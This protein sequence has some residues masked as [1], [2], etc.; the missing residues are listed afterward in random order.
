MNFTGSTTSTAATTTTT[1]DSS[2]SSSSD[3]SSDSSSSSD[4]ESSETA[5]SKSNS[6]KKTKNDDANLSIDELK[7]LIDQ[8]LNSLE[9]CASRF[10]QNYKALYRLTHF[11]LNNKTYKNLTKCRQLMLSEYTCK[12]STI[13]TGLFCDRK[14]TNFFNGIWRIPTSEIDR[15]G[16][17][18]AHMSRCIL[19]LMQVLREM[20]D[21]KILLDL[22]LTLKKTPDADKIYIRDAERIQLSD[23]ALSLCVQS[24]R[25]LIK[26]MTSGKEIYITELV[27]TDQEANP[28]VRLVM[29]LYRAYMKVQKYLPQKESLFSGLFID[30]Y[31]F[32]MKNKVIIIFSNFS[33]INYEVPHLKFPIW[34]SASS[35]VWEMWYCRSFL[36]RDSKS[37]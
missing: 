5:S 6:S 11:Y 28:Q 3:E 15:P 25:G 36:C 24:L 9:Q 16:S 4:S 26:R 7:N 1:S 32:Y 13:L 22:C 34:F 12:D 8:C 2:S 37:A 17:F 33:V 23:Q 35:A 31:K 18:A 19:L 20:D 29:D 27:P 10:P 30:T 21:H 14:M